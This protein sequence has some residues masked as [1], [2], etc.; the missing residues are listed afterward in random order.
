MIHTTITPELL[1]AIRSGQEILCL[2]HVKPDGD[3]VSS[4]L[5]MAWLLRALGKQP[6]LALQDAVPDEGRRLPGVE[7]IITGDSPDYEQAV[8]GRSF[9]LI[10]CLDASSPDRMGTAYNPA[11]HGAA[12]LV[13]I[14]HH[15]TNTGFGV[16]NWVDPTSVSTTQMVARLADAL[17]V[18]LTGPLAACL[19]TGLVTDTLCFSTSNVTARTLELAVRL[20]DGGADLAAIT[21]QTVNRR[22][23]RLI[24]LWSLVLPTVH[25]ADGVIWA[26]ATPEMLAQTGSP[27]SEVGLS[28][29]LVTADEADMSA[30]FIEQI[31]GNG[32][33]RVECSFR[34]KPGFN[35][36]EVAFALGGGGHPAAAGCTVEGDLATIPPRVVAALQATRRRQLAERHGAA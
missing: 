25:L 7:D 2:S 27:T 9:D 24:K 17:D 28:S 18:P 29:Y 13:V 10:I 33:T 35:V 11:L 3:A 22:P 20:M 23:F 4:L 21:Q 26:T 8:R 5:G 14:D 16:V 34:A 32:T 6:L 36:A 30:V 19:L 15:V 12:T 1:A 31:N